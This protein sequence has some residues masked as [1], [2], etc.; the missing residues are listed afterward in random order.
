MADLFVCSLVQSASHGKHS[1]L[2]IIYCGGGLHSLPTDKN[3]R[4]INCSALDGQHKWL[5][6]SETLWGVPEFLDLEVCVCTTKHLVTY[7]FLGIKK[8][9]FSLLSYGD[10]FTR[11]AWVYVYIVYLFLFEQLDYKKKYEAAKAHWH[12]TVDRP[13][14][15]QAAKSSLQ[16]SD[17]RKLKPHAPILFPDIARHTSGATG[18]TSDTFF[19][20]FLCS[21]ITNMTESTIEDA[22]YP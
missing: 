19:L 13:D 2:I 9:S 15:I 7:L 6:E 17:V 10:P 4:F 12:W 14:F 5:R 18:C 22:S 8:K 1:P 16:Q 21:M 20:L 11:M 3:R